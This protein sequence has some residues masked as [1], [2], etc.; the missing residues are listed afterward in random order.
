MLARKKAALE[1]ASGEKVFVMSGVSGDGLDEVLSALARA[2]ERARKK[3]E[4]KQAARSWA[5]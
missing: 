4:P 5:P 3:G 1:K 2:V